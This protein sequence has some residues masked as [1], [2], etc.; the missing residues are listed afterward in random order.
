MQA[1]HKFNVGP[2][3]ATSTGNS[4]L[5]RCQFSI[6]NQTVPDFHQIQAGLP[7]L[8]VDPPTNINRRQDYL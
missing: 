3:G 7:R 4:V 2:G 8:I 5:N 1:G 6:R